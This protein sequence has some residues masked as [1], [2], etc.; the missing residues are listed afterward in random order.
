[1]PFDTD[2]KKIILG[3]SIFLNFVE[4]NKWEI[5]AYFVGDNHYHLI[6]KSRNNAKKISKIIA[7]IH[8]FTAIKVNK[9]DNKRGRKV[10]Y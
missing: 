6:I 9:I 3:D 5:K 7:D 2:E 10:C 8:R 4:R 1:M